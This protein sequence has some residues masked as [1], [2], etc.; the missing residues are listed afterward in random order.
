MKKIVIIFIFLLA[1]T[2]PGWGQSA[3]TGFSVFVPESL[4]KYGDGSVSMEQS[5]EF[6]FGLSGILSL[7]VGVT[8]NTNYG[9]MVDGASDVETPW[10]YSDSLMPYVMLKAHVP[11]GIMYVEAFGGIATNYNLTLRPI[12]G[13]IEKDLS[14]GS[15]QAVLDDDSI[16]YE[17]S[18]GI[19]Y[20]AG[21]SL[22]VKI[23]KISVDV[24]L[25]YRCIWHDLDLIGKYDSVSQ[26]NS[27]ENYSSNARLMMRGVS[28]GIGGSF[29]F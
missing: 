19:G 18:I 4:Y 24:S 21:G 20:V 10:F 8:Y 6:S 5:L 13:N 22:G 11:L 1:V 14:S 29:E 28:I 16:E 3:G 2:I 26:V 27:G 25:K 23:G 9:L 17:N 15:N 12:E 7:P